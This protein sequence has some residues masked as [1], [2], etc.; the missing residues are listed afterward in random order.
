MAR[1]DTASRDDREEE[2]RRNMD[3]LGTLT[4]FGILNHLHASMMARIAE[5]ALNSPYDLMKPYKDIKDDE[6]SRIA[7]GLVLDY[8]QHMHLT[9]TE[10][11]LSCEVSGQ[12][13]IA[14]PQ[15]IN[16]ELRLG[17]G[18][19]SGLARLCDSWMRNSQTI[20]QQ[21][22]DRLLSDISHRLNSLPRGGHAHTAHA[23]RHHAH[24]PGQAEKRPVGSDPQEE[25]ASSFHAAP[26]GSKHKARK[27]Q[28]SPSEIDYDVSLGFSKKPPISVPAIDDPYDDFPGRDEPPS[29]EWTAPV[30]S[31]NP[32][33][34]NSGWAQEDSGG[35][36]EFDEPPPVARPP[37]GNHPTERKSVG[38]GSRSPRR[39]S[40]V[41]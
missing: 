35:F 17:E 7:L 38:L 5:V 31:T 14:R 40:L 23:G 11:T 27:V 15:V 21:N 24:R 13:P 4:E 36:D 10:Q 22:Q 39:S 2:K 26:L 1:R 28:T 12:L 25:S 34:T 8:I 32:P 6:D 33:L 18:R 9:E 19:S 41:T 29:S 20:V 3:V 16:S 37:Q 30:A